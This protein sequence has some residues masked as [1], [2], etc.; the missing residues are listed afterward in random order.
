MILTA[1]VVGARAGLVLVINILRH[2]QVP[3]ALVFFSGCVSLL[4]LLGHTTEP[5]R[6]SF[7]SLPLIPWQPAAVYR[8]PYSHELSKYLRFQLTEL[9]RC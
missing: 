4:L 8:D 7:I 5:G 1:K 6:D 2:S 3:M 9:S